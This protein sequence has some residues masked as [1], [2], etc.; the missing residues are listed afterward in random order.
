MGRRRDVGL[1]KGMTAVEGRS[2]S[3]VSITQNTHVGTVF[4]ISSPNVL[5]CS[6]VW[7]YRSVTCFTVCVIPLVC[8]HIRFPHP[9]KVQGH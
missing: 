9:S 3:S 7:V 6:P 1:E 8:A 4:L 2:V 5:L